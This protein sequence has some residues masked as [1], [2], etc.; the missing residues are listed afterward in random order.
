M[1]GLEVD[2]WAGA[3]SAWPRSRARGVSLLLCLVLV[4]TRRWHGRFTNDGIGGVQ[5]FHAVP[6]PRIGGLALALA[7]ALVWPVL[8]RGPARALGC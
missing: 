6:T 3:T 1:H 2:I 5:K 8:P 7:Y 4:V